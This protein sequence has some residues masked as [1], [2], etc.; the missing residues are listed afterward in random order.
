MRLGE[1]ISVLK[2]SDGDRTFSE[3]M[4]TISNVISIIRRHAHRT[5][6]SHNT[7]AHERSCATFYVGEYKTRGDTWEVRQGCWATFCRRDGSWL[8]IQAWRRSSGT[9]RV[10]D[11]RRRHHR[12]WRSSSIAFAESDRPRWLSALLLYR[13]HRRTRS[14]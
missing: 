2:T 1:R 8:E 10:I 11:A 3:S 14:I 9:L 13:C 4:T 12:S 6:L 5:R 7:A